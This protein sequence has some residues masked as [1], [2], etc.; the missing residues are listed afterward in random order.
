M[1]LVKW[2]DDIQV[3]DDSQEPT[4]YLKRFVRKIPT[5]TYGWFEMAGTQPI[6]TPPNFSSFDKVQPGD[7]FLYRTHEKVSYWLRENSTSGGI[8]KA[9]S[10]GDKGSL[11]ED[12]SRRILTMQSDGNPTWVLPKTAQRYKQLTRIKLTDE[13]ARVNKNLY[14]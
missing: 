11:N 13:G 2:P 3:N 10:I 14:T 12:F 6:D 5:L 4:L 7:L 8:W 9:I 1:E